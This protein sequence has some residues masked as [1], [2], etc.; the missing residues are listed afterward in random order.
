MKEEFGWHKFGNGPDAPYVHGAGMRA[1]GTGERPRWPR[2]SV[3]EQEKL[4][5]RRQT[6]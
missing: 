6:N 1:C 3:E 5:D 2:L 4:E